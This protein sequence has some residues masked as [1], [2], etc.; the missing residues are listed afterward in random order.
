MG[1]LLSF[2][3]AFARERSRRLCRLSK[4]KQN[5][6]RVFELL[7][8]GNERLRLQSHYLYVPMEASITYTLKPPGGLQRP[9]AGNITLQRALRSRLQ[10]S[11]GPL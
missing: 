7:G 2:P 4:V 10:G 5:V 8:V 3:A 1:A 9:S 6:Q 11:N